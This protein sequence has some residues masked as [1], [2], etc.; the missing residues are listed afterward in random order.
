MCFNIAQFNGKI[1]GVEFKQYRVFPDT[2]GSFAEV[3]RSEWPGNAS[4]GSEL[5]LNLSRSR[6]GSIRGL[7]FHHRQSDWWI[8]LNGVLQ[9][10]LADLRKDS[11]T[12]LKRLSLRLE[13]GDNACLLV[14]PGVAHGFLALEDASLIYAVNRFYDGSDEQ[15]VA[16]NDPDLNIAWSIS[17]PVLSERDRTNPTVDY[18]RESGLLPGF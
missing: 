1:Y 17:E 3:F 10:A 8:L 14:P 4:Y 11:P 15:G 7:H 5:Q 12:F 13:S 16:W 6:K 9:V 18:L 2:R